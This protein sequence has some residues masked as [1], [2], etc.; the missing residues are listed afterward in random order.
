MSLL[1][2]GLAAV[3]YR[4]AAKLSARMLS[5]SPIVESV[6]LHRS[7]A[8]GEVDFGRSDID[9]LLVIGEQAAGDGAVIASLLRQVN[10]A[11]L[12]NPTLS[13]IDVYE[14]SALSDF[15][16]SDTFWASSERRSWAPL[17]GKPVEVPPGP[18]HPEHA[19]SRFLLWVEWYFAIAVQQ[20]NRRNLRKTALESW[21]AYAV[22]DRLIPEPCLRRSE[23]AQQAR[24]FEA[25]LEPER[26]AEPAYAARFVFELA[27]RLHGSRRKPL[28][29]LARPVIFDAVTAPLCLRRRFVVVPHPS[30][31]L[32]P[33]A[34]VPGAFLCTPEY[35]DLFAH[36][37]NP[38]LH[39]ILPQELTGLGIE[40]PLVSEFA[41][42]CRFYGHTRF[43][44]M[45]GFVSPGPSTQ[46]ARMAILRHAV[47]WVARGGAPPPV[48]QAKIQELM[49]S[50]SRSAADYYRDEYG[51][52]RS[53]TLRIQEFLRAHDGAAE[54]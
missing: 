16:R 32:P 19:L 46:A 52:L 49:A 24:R 23:M 1:P 44:F 45:P 7:V 47:D 11:R 17:C 3:V 21:N 22:A 43:L 2:Q 35:L 50:G 5:A 12:V 30:F 26:L 13:H 54:V 37:K 25:G 51:P 14:P 38:F 9:L 36:P 34:F 29:R 27:A 53:E 39:W 48:S 6:L 4:Q 31:P 10:R 40:P 33:E 28:R 42:A 18:V 20:T 8:T 41:R 15:A